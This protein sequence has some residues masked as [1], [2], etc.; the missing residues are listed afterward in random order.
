MKKTFTSLHPSRSVH[1]LALFAILFCGIFL[2]TTNLSAQAISA[3][4]ADLVP[5][6]DLQGGNVAGTWKNPAAYSAVLAAERANTALL[7]ATPG[8]KDSKV[9]LYKGYDRML[10]YMQVDMAANVPVEKIAIKNYNRLLVE[11]PVDSTLNNMQMGEFSDLYN[12][13]IGK[14]TQ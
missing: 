9:A 10:G 1:F 4:N 14:L 11:T 6:S 2:T 13:L 12:T 5:A 8:I 7:L 3:V